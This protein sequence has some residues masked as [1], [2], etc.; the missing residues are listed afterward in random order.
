M[1]IRGSYENTW[2]GGGLKFFFFSLSAG[3][4]YF[5]RKKKRFL[6]P[7]Y[8]VEAL[9]TKRRKATVIC[10]ETG[11]ICLHPDRVDVSGTSECPAICLARKPRAER[12]KFRA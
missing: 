8:Y 5:H 1:K 6:F 4:V 11:I 10:M 7:C 2:E 12:K 9:D 3:G